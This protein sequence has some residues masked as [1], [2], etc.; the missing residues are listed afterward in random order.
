MTSVKSVST[1]YHMSHVLDTLQL[2]SISRSKEKHLEGCVADLVADKSKPIDNLSDELNVMTP[3]AIT[4]VALELPQVNFVFFQVSSEKYLPSEQ[5][6]LSGQCGSEYSVDFDIKNTDSV[7][8]AVTCSNVSLKLHQHQEH[9]ALQN[10]TSSILQ[11]SL[12]CHST[13]DAGMFHRLEKISKSSVTLATGFT[14]QL[15][16]QVVHLE[17]SSDKKLHLTCIPRQ[18]SNVN[19]T[20]KSGGSLYSDDISVI[21]PS[22]Q[23]HLGNIIFEA[24][25]DGI[26][27]Q[28]LQE[29]SINK[30]LFIR[31]RKTETGKSTGR[32]LV[33]SVSESVNTSPRDRTKTASMKTD[34][35]DVLINMETDTLAEYKKT[36]ASKKRGYSI[37][38]NSS[39]SIDSNSSINKRRNARKAYVAL[40]IDSGDIADMSDIEEEEH[41]SIFSGSERTGSSNVQSVRYKKKK[42][43]TPLKQSNTNVNPAVIVT[44]QTPDLKFKKVWINLA[45]PKRLKTIHND[46]DQDVNLVTALI[47]ALSCW[48]SPIIDFLKTIEIVSAEYRLWKYAVLACLM[49]Q[50]LPEQGRLLKKVIHVF[51]LRTI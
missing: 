31:S 44:E 39:S 1:Y 8:M 18:R 20:V 34:A 32:D 36:D 30:D 24:G 46:N 41:V 5:S 33:S 29:S 40:D 19:F 51:F 35:D 22:T 10:A 6:S 49:G 16:L 37:L 38:S 15:Q 43:D 50:S 45:A 25:I 21:D 4:T 7:L 12:T 9:Q 14:N 42:K 13:I 26:R 23:E 2:N 3:P 27:L 28:C 17:G 11:K 47:P 48:V